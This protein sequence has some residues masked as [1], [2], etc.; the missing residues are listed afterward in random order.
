MDDS[1]N[2]LSAD[3][4]QERPIERFAKISADMAWYIVGFTDGEGSFNVSFRK[5]SYGIGWKVGLSFNISQKDGNI[6]RMLQ[7][8]LECGTIRFRKDGVG[9]FEVCNFTDLRDIIIPFFKTYSLKTK[10]RKDFEVFSIIA[11]MVFSKTHL[12]KAGL[13]RLLEARESMNAGGK[14][15]FT[16]GEILNSFRLESSETTRRTQ[17]RLEM[18]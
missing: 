4:Q 14:R 16:S 3:N 2:A 17:A 9:Y 10:K 12:T 1:D 7:E 11:D 15:K 6:L 18:I 8:T 5:R 13:Q